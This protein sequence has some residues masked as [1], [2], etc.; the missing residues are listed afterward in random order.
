MKGHDNMEEQQEKRG[1][2]RPRRGEGTGHIDLTLSKEVI[3]FLR[4]MPA[5]KRS[6]FVDEWIKQHPEYMRMLE[7]E[8]EHTAQL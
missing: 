7:I 8:K 1:P 6:R 4:S 3:T 2:G 5:G